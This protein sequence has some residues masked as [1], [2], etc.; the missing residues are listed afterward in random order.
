MPRRPP[1][2]LAICTTLALL[3]GVSSNPTPGAAP[4]PPIATPQ[5]PAP[6]HPS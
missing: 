3:L 6:P 1:P 2:P 5:P 4:S